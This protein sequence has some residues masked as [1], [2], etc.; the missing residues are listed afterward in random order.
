MDIKSVL[1][2]LSKTNIL[3][4]LL[5]P[6]PLVEPGAVIANNP[7]WSAKFNKGKELFLD[8]LYDSSAQVFH[9]LD[10]ALPGYER[11]LTPANINE[12]FC[13]LHLARFKE[14]IERWEPLVKLGRV[15]AVSL[16]N[17]A[18]A[19]YRVGNTT[20]AESHLNNWIESPSLRFLA[21]AYLLLSVLQVH[22]DKVDEA[23]AS[24]NTALK[25]DINFCTRVVSKYLGLQIAMSLFAGEKPLRPAPPEVEVAAKNEILLE[26]GKLLVPRGPSKYPRLAQQLSDFEY[27]TGYMTA[28]EKFGDG[29]VH[30]ALELIESLLKGAREKEA[31]LWAKAACLVATREWTASTEL[32]ED[33]VD[34]PAI[35]GGVLWNAACAYF[36][37][38]RYDLALNSIT[39]CLDRE[40]RTSGITWLIKGLLAHLCGEGA[41]RDEAIKEAMVISPKQLVYYTAIFRQIGIEL[42]RLPS[43]ERF[44]TAGIKDE[45]LLAKYDEAVKDARKLL[46][47]GKH[48]Q[49]AEQFIQF[50]SRDIADIAEIGDTTFSP[51]IL[52]TCPAQLYDYKDDFLS[53]VSAFRAKGYEE[54]I[55]KFGELYSKIEGNYPLAV[56]LSASL[57]A[58]ESY[59]R[60]I[61]IL[62]NAIERKETGGAY[63]IRNL[64]SA[65]VRMGKPEDAFPWFSKLLAA[66]VKE[67]FNFTQ[68]A[69]IAQLLGR[70]EDVAT[71]LYSACTA[72][73]AESSTRLKG[74]AIKACLEV[75]D[76]DRAVALAKYFTKEVPTPYVIAGRTRPTFPAKDCRVYQQMNDQ[77]ERFERQWDKRA[78]LA[79]FSEVHSARETDYSHS[80][81][82][83]TVD[84]LFNACVFF[85]W[86]L[87]WNEDFDTAQEVLRQ[88]LSLLVDHSKFYSRRELSNRYY[89]LTN[90]YLNRGHYFW[91]LELCETGL[92]AD[93]SN[94]GLQKLQSEIQRRIE[95]IPE[96]SRRAS[97]ELAELPLSTCESTAEFLALLPKV[98]QLTQMFPQD[99]PDSAKPIAELI[100][101]VNKLL[102]LESIP[103]IQRKKEILK[104]RELSGK[105]EGELPLYLPK[106][107]ISALLP[108]LKGQKK[109]LDE[110]QTKSVCPEFTFTLEPTSYYREAEATLVYRLRNT[111]GA[112]IH[113]LQIK[114][115]T[116]MP[117]IWA[118]ILED[119][120]FDLVKK[121]E[122][123]WIDW[124]IYFD[125][126]PQPEMDIKP[127]SVLRFTGG[128]LRGEFAE[129]SFSDQE[130][131]LVPFLDINIDYPVIALKPDENNRLYGRENLL[132]GLKNSFTRSGQTRIPFLEGV[133]KVGKTSILYFLVARLSDDLLPVYVNFDT[134]WDNPFRLLARRIIDEVSRRKSLE[135]SELNQIETKEDFDQLVSNII[136]KAGIKRVVLLLDEFH[137]VIERIER[138]VLRGEFLG[139]LRSMYMG[140]E[141]EFSVLFADWYL[142][143]ELKSRI[144]A[145]LWT[146]FARE[147]ISFLPELDARAAILAPAQ[148]SPLRFEQDVIS[149]IYYYSNG[150]PWHVQW[151]C[152]ELTNYLNIQKRYVVLPQ[153]VD[154][155]AE[156]LLNEDRLF[157]EGVCRPERIGSDSQC[158]MYGILESL[159]DSKQDIRSWFPKNLVTS[160]RL[161]VDVNREVSRLIQLEILHEHQ[162]R[163][164]FC[165]PLHALWLEEKRRKGT[166][167]CSDRG[168]KDNQG[169]R[170]EVL[171]EDPGAEIRKKCEHLRE[172]KSQ[173]RFAL[174]KE[175]Q[176]FK[177]IEMPNEWENASIVV[178][179]PEAWGTFIKALRNLFVEDMLSQLDSWE[180]RRKFPNLNKELH[181]IRLRRN[182]IE[183]P[184]SEEGKKEEENCC[185]RDI[186]KR[187][188][189]STTEWTILQLR[190]VDRLASAVQA[191][192]KQLA[193]E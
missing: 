80:I 23:T 147:R 178:R 168:I 187:L 96:R 154:L 159:G 148:G 115:K 89:R 170:A 70:K 48:L 14:Y 1:G 110:I 49:A 184:T 59:S 94:K 107:F 5:T 88:A 84:A 29:D 41:I 131:R 61:D 132:R 157:N 150:Y 55:Q 87:F 151:I 117:E 75:K 46:K 69:Y 161:P 21:K 74:A 92:E 8:G 22:N 128:S 72:N 19:Y 171:P 165:S 78:A 91:A 85:G 112:D 64:I 65:Y 82:V 129:Q 67:Y 162:A 62:L 137:A 192:I 142:I 40:Y 97:E 32:L 156:R 189:T 126:V 130:T 60:A 113:G 27:R 109:A 106:A 58:T 185:L 30:E 83:E 9:E 103:L 191:T 108:V 125:S 116:E 172:L 34:D 12:S 51:L 81:E 18:F 71:A 121:D 138:G 47:V 76:N 95:K 6:A 140:P 2:P 166:D 7:E 53:G 139:D 114:I 44:P 160:L 146:D 180:D 118:P 111:G 143:D 127:R 52:P 188:P 15:Y 13:W 31:L 100:D 190:A 181:S 102:G 183:H 101:L 90:L 39:K 35:P 42:E 28:L 179:T 73:L 24:F 122:Q 144:P 33:Q 43:E 175:N 193:K 63:A 169:I 99:F 149:K 174:G 77:Y 133:R 120:S 186:G 17:L 145:Q 45:E 124:P 119:Q 54:A 163:L 10:I 182:C 56:N 173:L 158:V 37:Q 57:I 11:I 135:S 25:A 26:L 153:D 141:Q 93:S 79:Y 86:S 177:N 50:A 167:I 123:L 20:K 36:Y 68:M 176:V 66:S 155:I 4:D 98:S 136:G 152:S 134:T 105:V 104:L 3:D 38:G 164:R 16:W